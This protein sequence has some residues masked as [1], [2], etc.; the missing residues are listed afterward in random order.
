MA[1]TKRLAQEIVG[2]LK[3]NPDLPDDEKVLA[4]E[5]RLDKLIRDVEVGCQQS[6]ERARVN[7]VIVDTRPQDIPELSELLRN[8][9]QLRG[10]LN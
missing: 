9:Q 6:I 1:L 3:Y 2:V 7:A 4:I 10:P 5:T 8:S